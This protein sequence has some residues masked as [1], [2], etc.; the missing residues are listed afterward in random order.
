MKTIAITSGKGGVG[1]TA[2]AV[3][4]AL[5][6]SKQGKTV[7]LLDADLGLANVNILFG[8]VP[9]YNL[10]H[11]IQGLKTIEEI[12]IELSG[13]KVICGAAGINRLANLSEE[14]RHTLIRDIL[15][16]VNTDYLI[17]DTG[18]GISNSTLDFVNMAQEI[19]VVTNSDPT[20]IT[21]AYGIIKTIGLT[22]EK[23]IYIVVNRIKTETEGQKVFQ[24]IQ[25]IVDQFLKVNCNLFGFLYEEDYV[26]KSIK[27]QKPYILEYPKCKASKTMMEFVKRLLI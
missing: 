3:N 4:F 18:A 24:R 7:T 26:G 25:T 22:S 16:S 6:L 14:E 20:S 9:K 1:K 8:I 10:M 17:I 19:I 15:T 21:D 13:I 5:A 2:F 23:Q 11:V 27:D 12:T